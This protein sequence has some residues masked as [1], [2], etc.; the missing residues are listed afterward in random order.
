MS[1][2]TS[3]LLALGAWL[4]LAPLALS[5]DAKPQKPKLEDAIR[6]AVIKAKKIDDQKLVRTSVVTQ[7]LT[8]EQAYLVICEFGTGD[9]ALFE[10]GSEAKDD[11]FIMIEKKQLELL[12]ECGQ[13]SSRR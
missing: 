3:M 6:R 9:M 13:R 1:H 11:Q 7:D 8:D 10:A 2:K 4:C 5:Q 12:V